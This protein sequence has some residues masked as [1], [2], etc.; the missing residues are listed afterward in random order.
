MPM[1]GWRVHFT[2]RR[3]MMPR[4]SR[5]LLAGLSVDET[6]G[7]LDREGIEDG[8][9][10]LIA[11]DGHYDIDLNSYFLLNP[12]PEN[13]QVA[14]AHDLAGFLTF[15]WRHR[16]PLG[17]RSWRDASP[18]DRAA[19]HRWR[20]VDERGPGVKGST[21]G[22]EVA[23]VNTFYRWAVEAGFVE[24]NPILQ[25]E[26]RRRSRGHRRADS[27]LTPAEAPKDGHRDDLAWLPPASYRRWRDIGVRGYLPTGLR[28]SSFRGRNAARNATFCDLMVRT[29]LRLAE[30]ANLSVFDVP[31]I[32]T[33]RAY[34]PTRLPAAIAKN[35]SGRRIYIPAGVLRDVCDYIRFDRADLIQR[36]RSNGVYDTLPGKLLIE[37]PQRAVVKLPNDAGRTRPVETLNPRQRRRL[38]VCG[39]DGLE[40]AALWLNHD[41]L[42]MMP[43]SWQSMFT[44]ANKRCVHHGVEL[45]AHPHL[46]RH[47]YAV[48]TL[49]QL[50]REHIRELRDMSP[51][52]RTSYEQVFGDPLD[53]VRRR[54]GHRSV[55]TTFK[56]LHTLN[57]LAMET[58]LA[59]M[60]N[61]WDEYRLPAAE[62]ARESID[63]KLTHP[64]M[65]LA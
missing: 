9:P 40:P 41:G 26:A 43:E 18:E 54:L 13:T 34:A 29:G 56:Y 36:A 64:E 33:R 55:E 59:L 1:L 24:Q 3:L 58:R 19:Y 51:A 63:E 52:Q 47:T 38:F 44:D 37:D 11:P 60:P 7:W 20:R 53:W 31:T 5:P 62:L 48:V 25:R 57:E 21:W 8:A 6:S 50:Q 15:L 30:Q 46:L 14:I 4:S 27:G 42:P 65:K 22:R 32:D 17:K 61:E 39:I 49:E 35:G 45:R 2:R 23:T 10:F 28:D 16:H 12:A